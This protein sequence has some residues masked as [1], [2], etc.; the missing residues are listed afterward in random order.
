M[1][2]RLGELIAVISADDSKFRKVLDRTHAGLQAVGKIGALTALAGS[3]THLAVALAPAAGIAAALPAAFI[4][5]K[6]ASLGLQLALENV[7]DTLS[8]AVSGDVEEFEESLKALPP[9]TRSVVREMGGALFGLQKRAQEAFFA[10]MQAQARGLGDDLRGPVQDGM[11]A[12]TGSM[13]RLAARVLGVV[14]EARSIAFIRE[15]GHSIGEAIDGAAVGVPFLVRGIRDFASASLGSFGRA[16]KGLGR[17]MTAVGLWMSRMAEAGRPM[18]WINNAVNTLKQLGRIGRNVA[19][20]LGAVFAGANTNSSDLLGSLEGITAAMAGWATSSEGQQQIASTWALLKDTASELVTI[21]PLLAGPLGLLVDLLE[22]LPGGTQGTAAQ[23]LA[24]SIA[25]GLVSSKL[26]PLVIGVGKVAGGVGRLAGAIRGPDSSLRRF[27][28]QMS[29]AAGAAGSWAGR[30]AT[31]AGRAA[32]AFGRAA[33][34]ATMAAGRMAASAAMTAARVAGAWAMMAARALANAARMAVS[35]I[36][37]M[38]PVGLIVAAVIGAVALIIA[39]WD[40]VKRFVTETLPRAI[41][42]GFD[43]IVRLIKNAARVG[44]LGPVGLIISHWGKIKTF[45]TSTVPNAVKSGIDRAVRWVSGL[46]GRVTSAVGNM[47]RLLVGAGRDVL[48]G[49]WNGLVSMAS[50]LARQ[51]GRLISNIVPGPVKKVLG[52]ASPSKLFAE[53]GGNLAEGLAQGMDG[54]TGLVAAAAAELA[55]AAATGGVPVAGT[56]TASGTG[57]AAGRGGTGQDGVVRVEFNFTGADSEFKRLIRKIVRV[58]G[59]GN[60]QLAFGGA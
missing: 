44:F 52:I 2:L 57:S 48:I 47:G 50:W 7:G 28:G 41:K 15:L 22:A 27:G 20:T 60:V 49:F 37:A 31:A 1:A 33:L 24:W 5:A 53:Y 36:I 32:L 40:K 34:T 19:I 10:P 17:L 21:L 42:G 23:F 16:G 55:S 58:D 9:T 8:G 39:N 51:I 26:G 46:P 6:V 14:R 29:R 38:G 43:F 11:T 4:A 18:R 13:G 59:R 3:A 35:W 54:G 12:V 25:I 56:G 45:F 30:M